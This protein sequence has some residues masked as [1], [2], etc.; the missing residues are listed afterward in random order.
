[1]KRIK[2]TELGFKKNLDTLIV[3]VGIILAIIGSLAFFSDKYKNLWIL[4]NLGSAIGL[5]PHFKNF[6]YKNYFV[7]NKK[8]GNI[9]I[10]SKSKSVV[11][12]EIESFNFEVNE[13]IIEHKNKTQLTFSLDNIDKKYI[14]ELEK[15]L[16]KHIPKK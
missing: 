11:F 1:M 12:S 7:W 5:F 16:Q 6:F 9:K 13:L 4:L 8:G 15:V 10:N 2:F 14:F 3:V